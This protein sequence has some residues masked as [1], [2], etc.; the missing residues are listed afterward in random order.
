MFFRGFPKIVKKNV[1]HY[2]M[3]KKC[4]GFVSDLIFKVYGIFDALVDLFIFVFWGIFV[5]SHY[6]KLWVS[7]A[8]WRMLFVVIAGFPL[9]GPS[10][11][12][13]SLLLLLLDPSA[14]ML[15]KRI[16]YWPF[17]GSRLSLHK[18]FRSRSLMPRR[19]D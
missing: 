9:S 1:S 7:L 6:I 13:P 8:P 12:A 5:F 4:A 17:S 2:N 10:G 15:S 16:S 14:S 11:N 3:C 19:T 18:Y